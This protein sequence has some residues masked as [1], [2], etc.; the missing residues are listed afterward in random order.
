VAA[1]PS[2]QTRLGAVLFYGVVLLLAYLVYLVFEP[3]LIPLAWAAVIVV[4]FYPWHLQLE[5]RCGRTS[6]AAI[7]TAGVTL[8]LV[9]PTLLVMSAFVRQGVEAARL[10]E[11]AFASGHL[12]WANHAWEWIAHHVPGETPENLASLARQGAENLGKF[13]ASELGAALRNLVRFFFDLFVMIL[14]MFYLFR[15][16]DSIMAALRHSL[17]FEEVHREK[18]IAEARELIYASVTSSLVAAL[19]NGLVG[20]VAFAIARISAPVFWGVAIAFCSFVPLVGS[21]LVW[22]TAGIWLI[23]GGHTGRGIFVLAFCAGVLGIVD[24]V[25]RPWLISGKAQLSG[26]LVFIGV[27]GGIAVFGLLGVVLGPIVVAAAASV[28]DIYAPRGHP[29]H[30]ETA[31]SKP[32][33]EKR[34]AVLE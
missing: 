3:F 14:A 34:A 9:V 12:A 18:M 10:S 25:L 21:A 16:A 29:Q 26:L 28:L 4:V 15:D 33:G 32:V 23:V 24:N 11:Q 5:R 1:E 17:P 19:A 22:V 20:G 7:S 8:I 2:S 27:V 6:A 31:K 30:S 13:L